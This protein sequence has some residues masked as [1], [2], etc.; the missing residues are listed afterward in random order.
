MKHIDNFVHSRRLVDWTAGLAAR[1]GL[2]VLSTCESYVSHSVGK[3]SELLFSAL[4]LTNEHFKPSMTFTHKPPFQLHT[5]N[6]TSSMMLCFALTDVWQITVR[7]LVLSQGT[8]HFF[9][10][11]T[12]AEKTF[13]GLL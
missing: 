9:L 2:A 3:Y 12:Q 11:V 8:L 6:Y 7:C 1:L 13:L 5:K 10:D 4:I